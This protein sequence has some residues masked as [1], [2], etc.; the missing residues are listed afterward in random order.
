MDTDDV[1][2]FQALECL[3]RTCDVI[4]FQA[5]ECLWGTC[6]VIAL[7]APERLRD[8]GAQIPSCP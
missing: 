7:Q 4:T 1:T 6:D 2:T 3:W 8:A 5:P